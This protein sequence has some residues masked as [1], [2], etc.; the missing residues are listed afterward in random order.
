MGFHAQQFY[1]HRFR[2]VFVSPLDYDL[3]ESDYRRVSLMQRY[4]GPI[5]EEEVK[6]FKKII[7]LERLGGIQEPMGPITPEEMTGLLAEMKAKNS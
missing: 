2:D 3:A 5:S 7:K 4:G 1:L 6:S